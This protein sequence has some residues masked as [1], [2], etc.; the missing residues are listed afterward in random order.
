MQYLV[1][2]CYRSCQCAQD[3]F[4]TTMVKLILFSVRTRSVVFLSLYYQMLKLTEQ[5]LTHC[6]KPFI[7]YAGP[8]LSI[9][10]PVLPCCCIDSAHIELINAISKK[11]WQNIPLSV[12]NYFVQ[13]TSEKFTFQVPLFCA[14]IS[15]GFNL[16]FCIF[17]HSHLW[18]IPE[19]LDNLKPLVSTSCYSV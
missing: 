3:H 10:L 14:N 19:V 17:L 1:A 2:H 15:F 13:Y 16:G 9:P 5:H 4:T 7:L 8:C 11:Q 6:I 18:C 12:Q